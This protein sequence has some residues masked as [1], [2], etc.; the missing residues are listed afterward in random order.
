MFCQHVWSQWYFEDNRHSGW[1]GC[2]LNSAATRVLICPETSY[3][4]FSPYVFRFVDKWKI[5]CPNSWPSSHC[6]LH[7]ERGKHVCMGSWSWGFRGCAVFSMTTYFLERAHCFPSGKTC[8]WQIVYDKVSNFGA[9]DEWF[10]DSSLFFFQ[11]LLLGLQSPFGNCRPASASPGQ[12]LRTDPT[13]TNNTLANVTWDG[14]FGRK[15]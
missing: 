8:L 14:R 7:W 9:E 4:L 5:Q 11:L 13:E 12:E 2:I 1:V 10:W 6:C 3:L 15:R